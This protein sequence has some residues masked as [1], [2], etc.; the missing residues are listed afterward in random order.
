VERL[1][2]P[3]LTG[4]NRH[5]EVVCFCDT[6]KEGQRSFVLNAKKPMQGRSLMLTLASTVGL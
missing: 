3:C 6:R 4:K 1:L 5:R 2:R